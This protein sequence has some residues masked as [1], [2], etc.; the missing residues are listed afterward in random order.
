[1]DTKEVLKAFSKDLKSAFPE[2]ALTT[3][4]DVDKTVKHI[5]ETFYP[6]I[7]EILQK[8]RKFFD[9]PRLLFGVDLSELWDMSGVTEATHDAMWKHI[10][11][12]MFASFLHGNVKDK[13]GKLIDIAKSMLGGRDD[14]PIS[15]ILNDDA[16]ESRIQEFINYISET[17]IAKLFFSLIEQI[18]ITE[19]DLNVENPQE[20]IG[21]IQNPEHP[22][23]K[24][25]I[26]KIQGLVNEKLRKGEITKQQITSEVEEIKSKIIRS[27]GNVFN[28]MLGMGT[29]D[30]VDRPVL[31]TPE[32]RLQYRRDR[33]RM[34][35]QE[36]YK[37][38]KN[39]Q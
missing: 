16:A 36:K 24:K 1:M 23:I 15:K 25:M 14:D 12:V 28:E 29:K 27:F 17:R 39:S 8:D 37:N 6:S 30:K 34:K 3:E 19:F 26:Q 33:L 5:E 38:E 35:L 7:L 9:V 10:Q 2:Q 22:T 11:T 13:L 31:N 32:A 20:L 21:M 18:D 4:I